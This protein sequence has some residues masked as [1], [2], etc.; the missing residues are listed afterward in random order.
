VLSDLW[1]ASP[2]ELGVCKFNVNTEVRQAYMNVLGEHICAASGA[3][4]LPC[5]G[6]AIAAMHQ[7]ILGKPQLFGSCQKAHLHQTPYAE[8]LTAKQ[9]ISF[10]KLLLP[11]LRQ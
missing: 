1:R 2:I 10:A 4:L 5:I 7:V 3:D 6:R 9:G 11:P 8:M